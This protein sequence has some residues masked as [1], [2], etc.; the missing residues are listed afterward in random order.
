MTYL[1]WELV[2]LHIDTKCAYMRLTL[3]KLEKLDSEIREGW[4]TQRFVWQKMAM[5]FKG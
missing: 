1:Q 3:Y 4:G 2:D 5:G